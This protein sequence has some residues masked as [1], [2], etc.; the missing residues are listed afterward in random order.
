MALG[1]DVIKGILGDQVQ[2]IVFKNI[3][4][5]GFEKHPLL[6]KLTKI[7]QEKILDAMIYVNYKEN[8]IVIKEGMPFKPK[9]IVLIE[10]NLIYVSF[11]I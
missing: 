7:Q 4:R 1:R 10:G 9:I 5:W 8:D 11:K 6:S 2:V 3:Q